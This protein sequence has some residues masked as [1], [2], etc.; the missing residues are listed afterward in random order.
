MQVRRRVV[1]LVL[2]AALGI[3]GMAQAA[4][5]SAIDQDGVNLRIGPGQDYSTAGAL[6]LGQSLQVLGFEGD[7]VKVKAANGS[8]LYAAN[9]VSVIKMAPNEVVWARTTEPDLRLRA[10]P[11]GNILG[12]LGSGERVQVLEMNGDWWFVRRTNGQEGWSAKSFLKLESTAPEVVAPGGNTGGT[13]PGGTT[14]GNTGG[15]TPGGTTGGNTGGT[16]GGNPGTPPGPTVPVTPPEAPAGTIPVLRTWQAPPKAIAGIFQVQALVKVSLYQGRSPSYFPWTGDIEAGESVTLIDS[17][18]GWLKVRTARGQVGWAPGDKFAVSGGSLLWQVAPGT[19]AAG[20]AAAGPSTTAQREARLVRDNDGLRL[21]AQPALT[22]AILD[23]LA[24]N[25]RMT[26]L[27]RQAPW[28]KVQVNEKVGWVWEEYT[29]PAPP[30]PTT[31]VVGR[32][33][34]KVTQV[35]DGVVQVAIAAPNLPVGQPQLTGTTLTVAFPTGLQADSGLPVAASG[36]R[37]VRLTG[38]GL[39]L[40]LVKAPDLKVVSQAPGSLVLELRTTL[41]G[42]AWQ[43]AADR[44]VLK[45]TLKG[46]VEPRVVE[47]ATGDLAIVLPGTS[48]V[49]GVAMPNGVKA[50]PAADSVTLRL[51]S[52]RAYALKRTDTGFELHLYKPG[53]AGKVILLDP[54]HSGADPGSRGNG[55]AEEVVNLEDSLR[56]RA[57]LVAMG[58]TVKMTRTT[59]AGLYPKGIP[60]EFQPDLLWRTRMANEGNVDLFLSIHHNAGSA[61][62]TG[63]ESFYT[64]TTLNGGRSKQLAE[65]ALQAVVNTGMA[66]RYVKH[67]LYFVNR[68]TDAPSAIIEV[69]YLSNAADAARA[70]DPQFQEQVAAQLAKAIEQF[71]AERP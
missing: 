65:L 6:A 12:M 27:E 22:G 35:K 40:D 45:M 30:E 36:V 48:L 34:V 10:Q 16:P 28:V 44:S 56:L 46:A 53:L 43:E 58:A 20:F 26:V 38:T 5:L 41:S 50:T 31:P 51:S 25:V 47:E 2:L 1:S 69:G 61:L 49:P 67:D 29:I 57:A 64:S 59:Q 37:S 32:P 21:R 13:T 15:T 33:S 54:G 18:E 9:W 17:E 42:L 66:R 52:K 71:Y 70:K 68:Y 14:G 60:A 39:T 19:W 24:Q 3:P 8:V 55:I 4:T 7:W 11:N 63:A 23:V 62:A